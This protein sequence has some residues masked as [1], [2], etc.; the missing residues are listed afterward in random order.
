[1]ENQII[2]SAESSMSPT[3][4]KLFAALSIAQGKLEHA[5]KEVNN[6]FFKI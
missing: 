4:A 2:V 5:K 1:M 3:V 6:T